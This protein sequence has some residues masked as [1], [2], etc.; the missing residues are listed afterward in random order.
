M[1][2]LYTNL[3]ETS[4]TLQHYHKER[5][6]TPVEWSYHDTHVHWL[7]RHKKRLY[8]VFTELKGRFLDISKSRLCDSRQLDVLGPH[9]TAILRIHHAMFPR[10]D[11]RIVTGLGVG[12]KCGSQWRNSDHLT[13]QVWWVRWVQSS[14]FSTLYV[15]RTELENMYMYQK[16][17]HDSLLSVPNCHKTEWSQQPLVQEHRNEGNQNC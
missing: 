2:R 9:A 3:Q 7:S 16:G 11:A 5:M 12:K 4:H 6:L 8:R 10:I 17:P 14:T 13:A 15:P 1:L